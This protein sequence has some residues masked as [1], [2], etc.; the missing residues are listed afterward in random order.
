MGIGPIPNPQSPFPHLISKFPW[1]YSFMD[2]SYDKADIAILTKP[3]FFNSSKKDENRQSALSE[4]TDSESG[5]ETR[6]SSSSSLCYVSLPVTRSLFKA[7]KPTK[8]IHKTDLCANWE[9]DQ[10]CV[11][12]GN[13]IFAH[14]LKELRPK[15]SFDNYRTKECATFHRQFCCPYGFK[16]QYSHQIENPY[17][18]FQLLLNEFSADIDTLIK[19]DPFMEIS[20]AAAFVSSRSAFKPKRLG[21]FKQLA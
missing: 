20:T 15:T 7:V 10:K 12:G 3:I 11:Y 17:R 19:A 9:R 18:N 2:M 13:C 1:L 21:A 16:C 6:T 8:S 4:S 5:L 14:G